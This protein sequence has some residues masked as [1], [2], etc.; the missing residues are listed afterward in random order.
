MSNDGDINE[1]LDHRVCACGSEDASAGYNRVRL[2]TSPHTTDEPTLH[3]LGKIFLKHQTQHELGLGLLHR[4]QD[5]KP[6][7]AMVHRKRNNHEEI[8]T[9]EPVGSSP[10]HPSSFYISGNGAFMPFEYTDEIRVAPSRDFMAE[11]GSAL[12]TQSLEQDFCVA[13]LE[14]FEGLLV[15]RELSDCDGTVATRVEEKH[16]AGSGVT[17]VWAFALEGQRLLVKARRVCETQQSG[18]HKVT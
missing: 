2:M 17:T 16:Y 5:L 15:E 13:Y 6:G 14:P 10:L 1:M 3:S 11:L 8:C 4:H 12:K 18:G 9:M 7:H